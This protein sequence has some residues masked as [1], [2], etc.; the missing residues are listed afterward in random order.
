VSTDQKEVTDNSKQTGNAD[1]TMKDSKDKTADSTVT[2]AS[3]QGG[4]DENTSDNLDKTEAAKAGQDIVDSENDKK[5]PVADV[6][7]AASQPIDFDMSKFEDVKPLLIE[8]KQVALDINNYLSD[9]YFNY[10]FT[11]GL[12][13]ET[14]NVTVDAMTLFALSYIMQHEYN[15]LKFDHNTYTLYIPKDRVLEV[16]HKYFQRELDVF[17]VYEDLNIGLEDD[18]YSVVVPYGEW[19]VV[20]EVTSV[21][22]LGDFTLKV[23]ADIKDESSGLVKEQ[24]EAILEEENGQYVLVNYKIVEIKE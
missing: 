9:F 16:I 10:F 1:D 19:N 13:Q 5:S 7:E 12:D 14:G 15:E 21:E 24:V 20:H 2:D 17:N 4:K 8:D 6:Y 23:V 3:S 18:T 22:R 11:Q